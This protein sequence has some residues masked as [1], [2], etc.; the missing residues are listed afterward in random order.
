MVTNLKTAPKKA[1]NSITLKMRRKDLK[2]KKL[3]LKAFASFSRKSL[4]IKSKKYK[5]G[6]DLANHLAL[7]LQANTDGQLTWNAS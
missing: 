7:L 2:S 6:K 4:E 3:H 1:L 5:S